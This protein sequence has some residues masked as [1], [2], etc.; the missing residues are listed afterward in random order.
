VVANRTGSMCVTCASGGGGGGRFGPDALNP[1][2]NLYVTGLST[3]VNEKDLQEHFS[4]E[5]KVCLFL[6]WRSSECFFLSSILLF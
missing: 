4:R 6:F 1:G 5:G 2:N 3:R